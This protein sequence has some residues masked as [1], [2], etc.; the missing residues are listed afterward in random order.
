MKKMSRR[1]KRLIAILI[2]EVIIAI[3][4]FSTFA[5]EYIVEEKSSED[6]KLVEVLSEDTDTPSVD[7]TGEKIADEVI[8]D[9]ELSDNIE[10]F[11][12][13]LDVTENFAVYSDVAE[14][15]IDHL[16][17]N[18]ATNDLEANQMITMADDRNA[19]GDGLDNSDYSIIIDTNESKPGSGNS[20]VAMKVEGDDIIVGEN[21][22][23]LNQDHSDKVKLDNDFKVDEQNNPKPVPEE[24]YNEVNNSY[25][26][27]D[28]FGSKTE[29]KTYYYDAI[30][31][32]VY[33]SVASSNA[34]KNATDE[35]K[36]ELKAEIAKEV[37]INKNLDTLAETGKEMQKALET[38][39]I[40]NTI[41]TLDY[42]NNIIGKLGKE[43]TITLNFKPEDVGTVEF[44]K[45]L[46][47]LNSKNANGARVVICVNPVKADG[48]E[49]ATVEV[50]TQNAITSTKW[51]DK[52]NGNIVFSFGEYGGTVKLT[53]TGD[54][55][56]MGVYVAGK[57]TV[58]SNNNKLEGR[59]VADKAKFGAGGQELHQPKS[60]PTPTNTPVPTAT[61]TNTV[62]PTPTNTATP[63][64]TNT[65]TP[66]PTNTAT[67]TPTNTATPTPTNTATPTPTN[68]A[69]PT[70]TN[71]ATPTPTNTATP[72]PTNT[73]TPTPTAT[74]TPTPT[75]TETPTPTAT[76]TPTPT[77]EETSTP[78]PTPEETA[79]P[80][81]TET[82]TPTPYVP[83]D[84]PTPTPPVD[85]PTPTPP[86]DNPPPPENPPE[87]PPQDNPPQDNPPAPA[88]QVLGA[89]RVAGGGDVLGA[90]RGLDQAVLGKRRAPKTG[91]SLAIF[92]WIAALIATLGGSIACVIGLKKTK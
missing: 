41:S 88:P 25:T 47:K 2:V 86:G 76:E 84:T 33:D 15:N 91:D 57:G 71:T 59:L 73:A 22:D 66:T 42:L 29:A 19:E 24:G 62:T 53:Q 79:T 23:I 34:Y 67:P 68:T 14:M 12:E 8:V 89:R 51:K 72:T 20:K 30:A 54:N 92:V 9:E 39:K 90:R 3:N 1:T 17:G 5:A 46:D 81:P 21:S 52:S 64:P 63:T 26:D 37:Q 56:G 55:Y 36:A 28:T 6:I 50:K 48:Q 85:T 61:P 7:E 49:L 74:E 31:D 32:A 35:Q 18:I 45:A 75:A 82:P 60:Y 38:K 27:V 70:P 78:T 4:V 16:Q 11:N 77:P 83:N 43:D 69:T 44:A 65:A 80:T 87:N 13:T 58:D 40:T 10:E